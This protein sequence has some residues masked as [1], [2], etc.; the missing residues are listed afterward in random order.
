MLSNN[1]ADQYNDEIKCITEHYNGQ[2]SFVCV[3]S[4]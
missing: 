4:R 2:L 3:F 1:Y